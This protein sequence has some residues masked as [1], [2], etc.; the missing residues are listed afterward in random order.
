M[1][2]VPFTDTCASQEVEE[3]DD[4]E[5]NEHKE[6]YEEGKEKRGGENRRQRINYVEAGNEG[7]GGKGIRE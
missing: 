2:A 1:S 5:K 3:Q 7:G 4:K 6:K